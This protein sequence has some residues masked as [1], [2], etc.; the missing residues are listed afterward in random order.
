LTDVATWA[1]AADPSRRVGRAVEFHR[2]IGSTNDWA[3]AALRSGEAEGLA[4]VADL[5]TEGRGRQGRVWQSPAGVNL[6]V[7]VA[8]HPRVEAGRLGLLSLA[9][10]LAALDACRSQV[11][12]AE[13]LLRWPNDLVAGDGRKLGGLLIETAV[14]PGADP[15]AVI[16]IGINVNWRRD[17]MPAA[18]AGGATSLAELAGG[19]V[20][21]VELLERLLSALDREVAALE[22][23]ASPVPRAREASALTGREVEVDVS[24]DVIRG[25]VTGLADDGALLLET[26]DGPRAISVGELV[27]VR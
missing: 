18:I 8:L 19:D 4:V 25:Q 21:R 24:A 23:G 12:G 14:E 27:R 5:Q 2:Q 15:E 7:S 22:S 11:P 3:R 26:G 17:A 10:G 6:M 13:I 1:I 20:D 16:G 9:A